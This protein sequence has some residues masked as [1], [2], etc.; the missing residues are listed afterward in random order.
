M[1]ENINC[2]ICGGTVFLQD[3]EVC[4][5]YNKRIIRVKCNLVCRL[6]CN[7]INITAKNN[8]KEFFENKLI[9]LVENKNRRI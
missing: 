2:P 8:A 9:P 5:G 7:E 1:S 3:Y 4:V 6:C